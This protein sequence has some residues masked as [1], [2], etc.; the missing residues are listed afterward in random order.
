M[1]ITIAGEKSPERS[2]TG[3]RWKDDYIFFFVF[4]TLQIKMLEDLRK[5][6]L[7]E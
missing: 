4:S 3:T 5:A 6:G 7:P 2:T 1:S